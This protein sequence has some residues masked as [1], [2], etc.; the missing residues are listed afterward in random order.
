M[1][2]VQVTIVGMGPRGLGILQHIAQRAHQ[3]PEGVE[4]DVHL[5]DPGDTGQGAH[6]NRQP[7]YLLTNTLASQL[8]MFPDGSGP[9][10][11]DWAQQVGYRRFA[12]GYYRTGEACGEPIGPHDYLPRNLLGEYLSFASDR[13]ISSLPASVRV[14]HHRARAID[15]EQLSPPG[16]YVLRTEDGYEIPSDFLFLTTGHCRR[17][18]TDEDIRFENFV[19]EHQGRNDRLAYLA[20]CYPV[21]KLGRIVPGATVAVQ[22]FGLTAHDVIAHLT[23]GRGGRFEGDGHDMRYLPSGREPSVLLFSRQCLPAAARGINQKGIAGAYQP[24]FFTPEAIRGLREHAERER[25]STQ[26]DFEAEAVPLLLREMGYVYRSTLEQRHIRPDQY[27]FTA[28]DQAA[29]DAIV[30][31]LAGKSFRDL[32]AFRAFF[33]AFVTEDLEHAEEGNRTS[34]VKAATDA[35]RDVRA[36]LREAVEFSGLT[37]DSH[38]VFNTRWVPLM[39]RIAFG[40]PRR[41]NYEL[42]ALMNAGVVD[43]AGGPGCRIVPDP[44]TSR[45]TVETEF[46]NGP[47]IRH[48]DALVAARLDLFHPEAD[49]SPLTARLLARGLIR[50]YGNGSY[51]PGGVDITPSGRVIAKTGTPLTGVWALGYPVEGPRYYTYYLPRDGQKSR[52]TDEAN[53]AVCDMWQQLTIIE[54]DDSRADR[55]RQPVS[56]P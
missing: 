42:L 19:R 44:Q 45:F 32:D 40:P 35:I 43:L 56:I 27:E 12:G 37:P 22:G 28:A 23:I 38:R 21:D 34:P 13:T 49:S 16:R 17:T 30:D 8:T 46:T 9:S 6:S 31:P 52:F 55:Q 2:A 11:T 47:A 36:S 39:N 4:L 29:V 50:P 51:E 1:R 14:V 41:R 18:P 10:F 7:E 24:H 54:E 5:V 48:A 53:A 15:M 20:D 26:V 33:T 3:L 25:G